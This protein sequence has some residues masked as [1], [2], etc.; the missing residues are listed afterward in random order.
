MHFM[1][2]VVDFNRRGRGGLHGERNS[3]CCDSSPEPLLVRY[4]QSEHIAGNYKMLNFLDQL[5]I[6]TDDNL[7]Y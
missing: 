6:R 2:F 7:S 4:G 1:T 3:N 5:S